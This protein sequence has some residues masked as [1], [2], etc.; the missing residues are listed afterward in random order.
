MAKQFALDIGTSTVKLLVANEKSVTRV[1]VFP[2]RF[3]KSVSMMTNTERIQF[4]DD[5]KLALQENSVKETAVLA[6]LPEASTFG[7]LMKFPRMSMPELATAIKWELD[8]S[9]PFPPNEI[10]SS[11]TV[12][13]KNKFSGED[14][15]SAYVVAVPSK[16]SELYVQ[17]F[18]LLGL[19]PARLENEVAP[20]V[21]A[22]TEE[23]IEEAPSIIIDVGASGINIVLASSKMI[24]GSYYFSVGGT[25][26]TKVIAD[27]F[28]L[29]LEQAEQYKRTYG[30]QEDQL[31]GKIFKVLKPIID[32]MIGEVRK[33]MMTFRNDHGEVSV[34]R[35][36]VTG[37]GSYLLGLV[38]YLS[39]TMEGVEIIVGNPL[40]SV[41]VEEEF[42]QLG[43]LFSVAFGL[44]Q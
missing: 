34:N 19:E 33:M 27:T 2:N 30:M 8:Q 3:G 15:I 13:E 10:E 9:V 21:R 16:T 31:E 35:V 40:A 14:I 1:V 11:W 20:I 38:N 12:F 39:K 5:I 26:M 43:P 28:G 23:L 24:F 29:T 36:I 41:E 22:Y 25:A 7:K 17:L 18:E 42:K 44:T 6:S 32:N 4:T 37:G